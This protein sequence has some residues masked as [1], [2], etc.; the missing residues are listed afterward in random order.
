M[1]NILWGCYISWKSLARPGSIVEI[2]KTLKSFQSYY[3]YGSLEKS[4]KITSGYTL[5]KGIT[6]VRNISLVYTSRID[7]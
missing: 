5:V 1:E 6:S 2:F 7:F 4:Q 3:W